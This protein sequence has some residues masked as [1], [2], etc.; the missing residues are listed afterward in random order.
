ML[1]LAGGGALRPPPELLG[2]ATAID[3]KA[4][5][6][7]HG[8]DQ[9]LLSAIAAL[10]VRACD[11]CWRQTRNETSCWMGSTLMP[12]GSGSK[13]GS[14]LQSSALGRLACCAAVDTLSLATLS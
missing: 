14:F 8:R 3:E 7:L 12:S 2:M 10:Q 5:A 13:A 11:D 4:A 6:L 9:A 1:A